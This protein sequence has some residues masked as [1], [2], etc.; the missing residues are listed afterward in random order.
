M[1][2]EE[3]LTEDWIKTLF[4]K[5]E[6]T[7]MGNMFANK[8]FPIE[9][10]A[11]S[12]EYVSINPMKKKSTRKGVNVTRFSNFLFEMDEFNKREQAEI[13]KNSGL[14]WSCVVDTSNKSLHFIVAL[15]EDL[16]ERTLYTAYFKA[17][18]DVLLKYGGIVDEKCKDPG[19]FTRGPWGVNNKAELIQKKPNIHDRTQ[20]VIQ[21]KGRVKQ[22]QIDEWLGQHG[23]NVLDYVETPVV[24][25]R[26]KQGTS[27]AE[28]ELKFDW[29][30]KYILKGQE[31]VQGNHY[32]YQFSMACGLLRAGATPQEIEQLYL[33]KWNHIHE[34]GPIKGAV[35]TVK[36]GEEI[37][38]PTMDER[39]EYYRQLDEQERLDNSRRGYERADLPSSSAEKIDPRPEDLARYIVVGTDYFKIESTT[40]KLLPW[41]KTMFEKLYGRT[42][43]PSMLYDKFGYKP[44]YIS[45]PFP[46][47]LEADGRTRNT[48]IRPTYKIEPGPWDTIRGALK[49][50]FE[51][52]YDLI[53]KYAAILVCYPEAKLPA[54]WFVGPEDK[55]KSAV[56]AVFK[57]LVGE[58]NTERVSSKQLDSD[59]TDF[60]GG[61]QL[62]VVEE[63]GGWKNPD[64]VMSNL[65]DWVTEKGFQKLNPK[66]GKQYESPIHCK[67]IFSSN[68]FDAIPITGAATRFWIRHI[69]K[70]PQNKVSNFYERVKAE[71][72]HFV[73][74]LVEEIKPQLNVDENGELST[75]KS[76]LYF[77]PEEYQ[78]NIK[79]SLKLLN[80]SELSEDIQS[81]I[82]DFFAKY[83]DEEKCFAD[84]KSLK[85]ALGKSVQR[86]NR[87][88]NEIKLTLMKEFNIEQPTNY[89]TRPDHL[90]WLGHHDD[91]KPERHSR[92]YVFSRADF[93][94]DEFLNQTQY[95]AN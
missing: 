38:V 14:P 65:K 26:N 58:W 51:D 76:R 54:I 44:D 70:D 56:V 40:D 28:I 72:G 24:F 64:A 63:A 45:E 91:L 59:F 87:P 49:H 7:C 20:K 52:Q 66:Y 16:G 94:G 61:S 13:I 19:R 47:N 1:T 25:S 17:I 77:A 15:E 36:P 57:Y 92:W 39:R 89:L 53:L 12:Q 21:V 95:Y 11:E 33:S 9:K 8:T 85:S 55:G 67:F 30:A 79:S 90:N 62:V 35:E 46:Y 86:F 10:I 43:I 22:A 23:V 93:F 6:W 48:F 81:I 31:Y 4:N 18:R 27:N 83:P 75:D 29:I 50:G 41:N 71:M 34:N 78:T 68:D 69:N 60:L 5:G 74:Y 88:N 80:K 32:N 84:L 82:M 42:A 73:H 3:R 37:Y 2:K